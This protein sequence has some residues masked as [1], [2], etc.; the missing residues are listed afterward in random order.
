MARYAFKMQLK[1]ESVVAEYERLHEDIGDEVRA[2]HS[3]AG[4]HNYTIYRDG[5]T[6]YAYFESPD[7][8]GAFEKIEKEP[9]M[10]AWWA[11]TNPLMLTEDNKPVFVELPEVFHMD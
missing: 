3:R 4:F 2:A 8:K 10:E 1:D 5:L 6:L 7:P 9:I 11:K